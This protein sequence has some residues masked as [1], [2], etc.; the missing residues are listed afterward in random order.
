MVFPHIT[1]GAAFHDEALQ[2][3]NVSN[4]NNILASQKDILKTTAT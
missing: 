3:Q 1:E 2:K 4:H